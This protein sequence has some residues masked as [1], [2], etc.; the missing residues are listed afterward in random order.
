MFDVLT[1]GFKKAKE[2]LGGYSTLS[3]ENV[4]EALELVRVSLLDADVEYRVAKDFLAKVKEKT[5][6]QKVQ[7]RGGKGDKRLKVKPA[8]HFVKMCQDELEALMGEGDSSLNFPRHQ[9]AI[10]MM[11]GL[12]GVGKTTTTGKLASYLRKKHKRRPLLVAADVYRPAA[13]EQLR[14]LGE[15]IGVPVFV[16]EGDDVVRVCQAAVQE[17][18][19]QG[20]DTLLLDTAGRLTINEK[21]MSELL[22]IKAKLQP[23][24]TLLICDAMI[25]QDSVTTADSFHQAL[26]L[27]G[28]IMTKLDGDARGGAAISIKAVTGVSIKFLGMGEDLEKLEEFRP[29]GLASRILGLGDIVGLMQDFDD[30]IE[31]D[32]EEDALRMMQG[33]FNLKDFSEQISTLQKVGSVRNVMDKLP[34][35]NLIPAGTNVDD[36]E[37]SKTRVII[38]S[39]TE[40]E[41]LSPDIIDNSRVQRIAQGCGQETGE[42]FSLLK[43][44]KQMRMMMINVGK[45]MGL[46]GKIPLV[47]QIAKLKRMQAAASDPAALGS[48]LGNPMAAPAPVTLPTLSR[49]DR[50]KQKKQR[51]ATKAARRKNRKK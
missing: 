47:K 50:N 10:I 2:T 26:G 36:K 7:L 35:Q 3:E 14:V 28:A 4:A 33:S 30:V 43:K 21:L 16:G 25:G 48:M 29:Q 40:K 19:Q 12:Q 13:R 49:V 23:T 38:S 1:N 5:L 51:R 27:T 45:N 44:F 8:D 34:L 37:L 39:M 9:P 46:A 20:Y 24:D 42:V 22:Q 15:R 6:G 11:V 31:E 32:Q 18:F 17:S 41:R